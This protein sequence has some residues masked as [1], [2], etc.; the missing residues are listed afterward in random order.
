MRRH[1]LGR[2]EEGL[3]GDAAERL[4]K[5][6]GAF[7]VAVH[8]LRKRYGETLREE[9]RATVTSEDDLDDEID[10]LFEALGGIV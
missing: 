9:V 5:S 2:G 10:R 1:E 6:P 4:G 3:V 7:K 8:R